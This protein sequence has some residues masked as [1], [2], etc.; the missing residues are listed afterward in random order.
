LGRSAH[1]D[2]RVRKRKKGKLIGLPE[3]KTENYCSGV[4][5]N[6]PANRS[7]SIRWSGPSFCAAFGF[8]GE[9]YFHVNLIPNQSASRKRAESGFLGQL[10]GCQSQK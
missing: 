7:I 2:L 8:L 4:S 3:K 5:S 6:V 10:I 9:F 1:S